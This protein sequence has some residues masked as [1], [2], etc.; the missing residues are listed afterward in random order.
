MTSYCRMISFIW[1]NSS[2]IGFSFSLCTIIHFASSDPPRDTMPVTPAVLNQR[3][4]FFQN[5]GVNREIIDALNGL[6]LELL[7][8]IMS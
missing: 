3:Q 2:Y 6:P 1:S 5:A 8:R 4:M 7:W